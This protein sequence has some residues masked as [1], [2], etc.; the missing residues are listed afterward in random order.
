MPNLKPY[1]DPT[2]SNLKSWKKKHEVDGQLPH[3]ESSSFALM[4]ITNYLEG[5]LTR[6]QVDTLWGGVKVTGKTFTWILDLIKELQ[7]KVR[8]LEMRFD[9]PHRA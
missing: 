1:P 5:R 4:I 8:S 7:L 6:D 3:K 9:Y 2:F